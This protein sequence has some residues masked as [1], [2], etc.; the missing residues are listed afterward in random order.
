MFTRSLPAEVETIPRDSHLKSAELRLVQVRKECELA[1]RQFNE[2]FEAL[3]NHD[4]F[5][6]RLVSAQARAADRRTALLE[7]RAR[8][9]KE[10]G[11]IR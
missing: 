3:S 6:I 2:T 8:L 1:E 4:A 11:S 5:R 10:L 9:L 7:E